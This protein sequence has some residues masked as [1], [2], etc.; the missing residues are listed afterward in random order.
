MHR[1]VAFLFDG[2]QIIP[3]LIATSLVTLFVMTALAYLLVR[4]F[5]HRLG[6]RSLFLAPLPFVIAVIGVPLWIRSQ[7]PNSGSP[8][9]LPGAAFNGIVRRLPD[10]ASFSLTGA[11]YFD[12]R[13]Y[14]GSNVGLLEIEN[15]SVAR[16]F[17]MQKSDS[18]VS[19]PW[20]DRSDHLLWVMDEHTHEL[21]NFNGSIW[22]R[23][24]MPQPPKG[25]YSRGE[26]LEGIKPVG[27]N[28]G[29]W[30]AAAGGAWRWSAT[31]RNWMVE[32]EPPPMSVDDSVLGAL[33]IQGGI[34]Y[35]V[36][37]ELLPFLLRPGQPF[38][39]DTITLVNG[40]GPHELSVR[41]G[42]SFLA[43]MWTVANASAYICDRDG[44]MLIVSPSEVTPIPTPG[45]CEA[46]AVDEQGNLVAS[47][48]GHGI[49]RFTGSEWRLL[50][51]PMPGSGQGEYWAYVAINNDEIAYVTDAKPVVDEQTSHGRNMH[52][53]RNAETAAWILWG[54]RASKVKLN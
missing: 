51:S 30:V 53:K 44:R 27:T 9:A 50:S 21:L 40:S 46:V 22:Q 26:V 23:V 43:E 31:T 16:L 3:T 18:V 29:F 4:L 6:K 54:E 7:A 52:W 12:N 14:I 39:S 17:Q 42:V 36:R 49:F 10:Y 41:E 28:A 45:G 20:F 2:E 25:Y 38:K 33:P 1:P 13:L 47:F 32:P 8:R 24:A 35:I 15:G 34:A 48:R 37:H 19:G 5:R 11:A